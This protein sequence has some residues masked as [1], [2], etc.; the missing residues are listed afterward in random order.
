VGLFAVATG[1]AN[2]PDDE[3]WITDPVI[4]EVWVDADDGLDAPDAGCCLI[5]RGED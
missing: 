2:L 3:A 1:D 4:F 5:L